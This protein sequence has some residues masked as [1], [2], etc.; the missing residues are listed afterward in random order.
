MLY[1]SVNTHSELPG[2]LPPQLSHISSITA[3]YCIKDFQ[4][5]VKWA[6]N[7]NRPTVDDSRAPSHFHQ[8]VSLW[9][10]QGKTWFGHHEH[11]QLVVYQW[12]RLEVLKAVDVEQRACKMAA[13]GMRHWLALPAA[14]E[15]DQQHT[16]LQVATC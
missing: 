7:A 8:P 10:L 1:Y 2:S 14:A 15:L 13:D 16:G 9:P 4:T 3:Y 5:A 12:K 11:D 6:S